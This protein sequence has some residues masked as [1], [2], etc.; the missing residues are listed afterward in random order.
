MPRVARM[1]NPANTSGTLKV[2]DAIIIILPIP[3]L[4]ATVSANTVPT[5]ASVTATFSDAKKYGMARGSPTFH[6]MSSFLAFKVLRTSSSSGSVV[7]SP[8][9]T[10]TTTGK[11]EIAIDVRIAG[12]VP[13]PNQ[14]NEDRNHCDF[15]GRREADQQR[16]RR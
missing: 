1:N 13:A 3:R 4:D 11:I 9:A 8:V 7:A 16:I 14:K 6:R 2:E 12:T 5:K 15:R 10:F